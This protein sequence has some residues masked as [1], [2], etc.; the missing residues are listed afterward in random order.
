MLNL[1]TATQDV[2]T[3]HYALFTNTS[4]GRFLCLQSALEVQI[5]RAKDR[6]I[7]AHDSDVDFWPVQ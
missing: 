1:G 6:C 7:G 5:K 2:V 3:R 4:A